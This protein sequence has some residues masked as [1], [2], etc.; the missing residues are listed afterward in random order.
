MSLFDGLLFFYVLIALFIP[1]LIL[2]LMEKKIKWYGFFVTLVFTACIF[3]T[4]RE[5]AVFIVSFTVLQTALVYAMLWV[6][7][8]CSKKVSQ[9]AVWIFTALSLAPLMMS[10]IGSLIHVPFAFLGVSYMTFRGIQM[11]LEIYDGLITEVNCFEFIYFLLYFPSVSSGPID[12]FRRF[13]KDLDTTLT[14]E[15]YLKCVGEGVQ[16]LF[17][18]ALY[19]FVISVLIYQKIM[20]KLPETFWG[21]LGYMYA[22][23]IFLFFNFAG[24]SK[25]AVGAG[26]ILGIRMPENFNMPFLAKDMKDFYPDGISHCP[27]GSETFY[28]PVLCVPRF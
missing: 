21:N 10:K 17:S 27:P 26:Y 20:V 2:G 4:S 15:E 5:T 18:G 6:K 7:K 12:R 22:Y 11:L 14:R 1:A 8:H 24:Y 9:I 19:Y 16:R 28:I 23:T 13:R 25:M 3:F